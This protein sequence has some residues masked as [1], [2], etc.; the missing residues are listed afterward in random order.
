MKNSSERVQKE[1]FMEWILM[2]SR[3]FREETD[4]D[5]EV[6]GQGIAY[7]RRDWNWT[8]L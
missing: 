1:K 8:P 6:M 3:Y 5:H 2:S 7:L 4:E